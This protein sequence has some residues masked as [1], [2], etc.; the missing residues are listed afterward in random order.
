MTVDGPVGGPVVSVAGSVPR[1]HWG[2]LAFTALLGAV[3]V[4]ATSGTL[5]APLPEPARA[6]P[7]SPAADE[8]P[9]SVV[10]PPAAADLAGRWLGTSA[11]AIV[12][13]PRE[14][15]EVTVRLQNAGRVAWVRGSAAELRL[16]EFSVSPL[17]APMRVDW[18]APDRPAIQNEAVV[19][20]QQVATFTVGVR[21]GERGVFRLHLRPVVDDVTWLADDGIYVDITVR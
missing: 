13:A 1:T 15:A 4:A 19:R 14:R 7:E 18:L 3:L 12:I 10:L 11:T 2:A 5:L 9:N 17:P 20:P 16:G 21:G 6:V 8:F